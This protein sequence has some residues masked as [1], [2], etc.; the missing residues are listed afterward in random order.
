[1]KNITIFDKEITDEVLSIIYSPYDLR[2][3]GEE[4]LLERISKDLMTTKKFKC[5]GAGISRRA[6]E[7]GDYVVKIEVYG[8]DNQTYIELLNYEDYYDIMAEIYAGCLSN[9]VIIQ[10]KL[11]TNFGLEDIIAFSS[12]SEIGSLSELDGEDFEDYFGTLISDLHSGNIGFDKYDRLK[13]LD[14]G[15]D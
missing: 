14:M 3:Y 4:Y 9:G 13:V 11:D 10:E 15:I 1:M 5:L 12:N 7:V 8:N 6:Y 2:V